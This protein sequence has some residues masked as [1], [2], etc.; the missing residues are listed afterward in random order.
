MKWKIVALTTFVNSL[1]VLLAVSFPTQSHATNYQYKPYI[2]GFDH[3]GKYEGNVTLTLQVECPERCNY[4][5]VDNHNRTL[6]SRSNSNNS[7]SIVARG[8]YK[9]IAWVALEESILLNVNKYY[10]LSS[11]GTEK[12]IDFDP[13]AELAT[14]ITKSGHV[15]GVDEEGILLD[16]KR[17]SVSPQA[18]K[19][20]TIVANDNED[21]AVMAISDSRGI[22]AS[23]GKRWLQTGIQLNDDSDINDVLAEFLSNSNVQY[24]SAYVYINSYCKGLKLFYV[25]HNNGTSDQGWLYSSE[26]NNIGYQPVMSASEESIY[27]SVSNSSERSRVYFNLHPDDFRHLDPAAETKILSECDQRDVNYNIGTGLAG[28][29]WY[30]NS[31]TDDMEIKYDIASSVYTLGHFDA[32]LGGTRLAVNVLQNKAK[33]YNET[34]KKVSRYVNFLVDFNPKDV[35]SVRLN[36]EKSNVAGSAT[37][38]DAPTPATVFDSKFLATS[39]L[40]FGEQ[41][42]YYGA[43]YVDYQ[44][45]SAISYYSQ[46]ASQSYLDPS[47]RIRGLTLMFG[48]DANAYAAR[49]ENNYSHWYADGYIGIGLAHL[50]VSPQV[51]NQAKQDFNNTS[52]DTTITNLTDVKLDVGYIQQLRSK[53]YWGAGASWQAGITANYKG[54]IAKKDNNNNDSNSVHFT[55]N[56][57]DLFFGPFV[58]FSLVM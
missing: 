9:D 45:P 12:H 5:L 26:E 29:Y 41:G 8:F 20:A 18:L 28:K 6:F 44:M 3:S 34:T 1:G 33:N 25:D 48:Y 42:L 24:G 58:R 50:R 54:F 15:Y 36:I 16:G 2:D 47:L 38:V 10:L 4:K 37:I 43:Q 52:L 39:L 53:K 19:R 17:L 7:F 57:T 21:I 11:T 46:S 51:E 32:S 35:K 55:F 56:R 31:K 49:Y 13:S 22:L 14:V 30:A 27:L 40:L 23:N